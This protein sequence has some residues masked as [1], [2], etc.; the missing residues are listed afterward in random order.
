MQIAPQDMSVSFTPVAKGSLLVFYGPSNPDYIVALDPT[1]G[2]VISSLQLAGNYDTT[3]GVYDPNTG[4]FFAVDRNHSGGNRIVA[5][6]PVEG[7]EDPNFTFN[8]PF[9]LGD[10][11]LALD[12]A[13]SGP[14]AGTFW[15]ASDGSNDIVQVTN[16][17]TVLRH[18]RI[19]LQA[20]GNI[21]ASG[22]AFDAAGNLLVSTNQGV[23][24]K[25]NVNADYA[26]TTPTLTAINATATNGTPANAAVPSADAGQVITLTGTNFNAGTE[27]VFQIRDAS[28]NTS[29]QAVT[30]LAINPAGTTLQVQVPTLATTGAIQVVNVVQP[31]PGLRQQ[32]RRDLSRPDRA[33]HRHRHP[34]ARSTSPTAGRKASATRAGA[35]TTCR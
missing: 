12:P 5:I 20:P 19:G 18:S 1:T 30:P 13:T 17:G 3:A 10:G 11:G 35:S 21:G 8:A 2:N 14:N 33:V 7:I 15:L 26:A 4:D 16:T 9:N 22:I 32:Q 29:Q 24:L 6:E 25:L 34:P 27:V 31:Q 28:G 23:V